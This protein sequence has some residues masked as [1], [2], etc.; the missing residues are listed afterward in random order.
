LRTPKLHNGTA[1]RILTEV[2][3]R[4]L[5]LWCHRQDRQSAEC[6]AFFGHTNLTTT[7]RYLNVKDTNCMELNERKPLALVRG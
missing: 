4:L 3:V 6:S 5:G 1:V 7:A 2:G